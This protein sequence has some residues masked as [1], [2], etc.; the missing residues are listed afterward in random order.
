MTNFQ[1]RLRVLALLATLSLT[2]GFAFASPATAALGAGLN[3]NGTTS[4]TVYQGQTVTMSW[5]T[6]D[7]ESATGWTNVGGTPVAF[8]AWDGPKSPGTAVTQTITVDL[9]PGL[10]YLVLDASDGTGT[11]TSSVGLTVL[12]T[13]DGGGDDDG[14]GDGDGGG[15]ITIEPE[16][17]DPTDA[18]P[19]TA[20]R[21]G[22]R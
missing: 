11:A 17:G 14:D 5:T 3:I 8:P 21:A 6:V 13:A 10:Y 16:P 4:A 12:A 1:P 15:L 20:P 7:A 22:V 9:P 19:T 18:T 2:L